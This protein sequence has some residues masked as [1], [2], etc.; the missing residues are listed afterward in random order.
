MENS[1]LVEKGGGLLNLLLL[2]AGDIESNPGPPRRARA[3]PSAPEKKEIPV[4][5]EGGPNYLDH[6][7]RTSLL[8]L[9]ATLVC[10]FKK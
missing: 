8:T 1:G 9:L 4:T 2:K 5:P 6:K 3:A 7:V 10:Y